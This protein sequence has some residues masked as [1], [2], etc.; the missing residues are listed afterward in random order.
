MHAGRA[1]QTSDNVDLE[2][3]VRLKPS[4]EAR[5]R[6]RTSPISFTGFMIHDDRVVPQL[7]CH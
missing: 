7:G 2:G 1:C 6:T 4:I 3:I 5:A